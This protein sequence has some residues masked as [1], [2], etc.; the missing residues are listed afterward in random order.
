MAYTKDGIM[1]QILVAFGQGTGAVRVSHDATV[2]LRNRYYP[3]ITDK[4][5]SS[6]DTEAVQVLE[7]IRAIGRLMAHDATAAGGTTILGGGAVNTAATKIEVISQTVLCGGGP[8]PVQ[9]V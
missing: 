9:A 2:E 6:W 3:M 4:V 5:I 1:A 7:R 8:P